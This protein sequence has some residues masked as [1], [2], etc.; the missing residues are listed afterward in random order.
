MNESLSALLDG[1]CDDQDLERI[2]AEM[3]KDPA[4]RE[5]F[6]RQCLIRDARQGARVRAPDYGF[7]TRVLAGVRG[8]SPGYLP[9]TERVRRLPWRTAASLAAAAAVGAVAVLVA[10][11]RAS[12]PAPT[13]AAPASQMAAAT[14]A[15]PVDEI[16]ALDDEHERQL[17]NYMMAYN[18]S[19]GEQSVRG[20]LGYARYAAYDAA[21]AAAPQTTERKP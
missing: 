2:L 9:V 10:V 18:R 3:E 6:S 14:A 13:A 5:Q 15:E 12:G 1:E 7:S 4:L 8:E 16:D 20:V 17:R 11:P 21:D 19:R